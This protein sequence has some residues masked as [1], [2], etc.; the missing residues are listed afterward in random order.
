MIRNNRGSTSILVILVIIVLATFGGVAVTSSWTNKK[1]AMKSVSWNEEYCLQEKKAEYITARI[2]AILLEAQN[3]ALE[4]FSEG[5]FAQSKKPSGIMPSLV[6][7]NF[8]GIFE[9]SQSVAER[10]LAVRIIFR[11]LYYYYAAVKLHELAADTGI[12]VIGTNNDAGW[13]LDTEAAAPMAGDLTVAFSVSAGN[14]PGDL[15]I[16]VGMQIWEPEYDLEIDDGTNW[17]HTVEF[18][19]QNG[20]VRYRI[21]DWNAGQVPMQSAGNQSGPFDGTIG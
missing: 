9:D 7:D 16:D 13:F 19:P 5:N 15:Y 20:S 1:L 10:T 14:R 2:D 21:T 11:R 12:E 8:L 18:K 6:P 3:M 17:R 4:Y